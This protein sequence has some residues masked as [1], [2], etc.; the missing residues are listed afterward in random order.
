MTR[1]LL[2]FLS[3]NMIALVALFVALGGTAYAATAL[4]AGSVGTK[5]L[6]NAAV[7]SSKIK[8][9]AVNGAKVADNSIT[10]ADVL[11]SSLGQVPSAADATH[12]VNADAVG[13]V[14]SA[15]LLQGGGSVV[16]ARLTEPLS[17]GNAT[18]LSVPG[19]GTMEASTGV[20]GIPNY[21][22]FWRN[23][24]S[25]TT[26]DVWYTIGATTT[27]VKIAQGGGAYV[28]PID[29][30]ADGIYTLRASYG[31]HVATVITSAH[32]DGTGGVFSSQA[33]AQ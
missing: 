24:L 3:H 27:Y 4:P 31:S 30:A 8:P 13:G 2:N 28:A 33:I 7:A 20:G 17:S 29:T 10:G 9:S 23:G 32:A 5:Q 26:V 15:D 6:K 18:I 14:S 25:G 21:R 12:A 16:N 19:F 11:E 22:L 1:G